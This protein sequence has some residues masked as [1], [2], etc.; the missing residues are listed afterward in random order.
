MHAACT[1]PPLRPVLPSPLSGIR[2]YSALFSCASLP[3]TFD[4]LEDTI[5]LCQ[6]LGMSSMKCIDLD[7]LEKAADWLPRVGG[8]CCWE[9]PLPMQ[10][11]SQGS[12]SPSPPL[13]STFLKSHV[14]SL[15]V[16]PKWS[17]PFPGRHEA[18][19]AGK[20]HSSEL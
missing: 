20:H 15:C 16:Q 17:I 9:P 4:S 2:L 6:A 19:N 18:G 10:Q 5:S 3:A 12:L 8:Q 11:S 14:P 7:S 1:E 13:P